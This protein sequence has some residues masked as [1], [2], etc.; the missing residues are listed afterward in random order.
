MCVTVKLFTFINHQLSSGGSLSSQ[1]CLI[2]SSLTQMCTSDNLP[3]VC[4]EELLCTLHTQLEDRPL[5]S[6]FCV[7]YN[8]VISRLCQCLIS[9]RSFCLQNYGYSLIILSYLSGIFKKLVVLQLILFYHGNK[10]VLRLKFCYSK[11]N[12]SYLK[13]T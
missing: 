5:R 2:S 12:V 6:F 8:C 3:H 7:D 1:S 13:M 11:I 9:E 10:K 4:L